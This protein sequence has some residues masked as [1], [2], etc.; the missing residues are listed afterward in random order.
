MRD[1][2]LFSSHIHVYLFNSSTTTEVLTAV[3]NATLIQQQTVGD[4]ADDNA[5][6]NVVTQQLEEAVEAVELDEEEERNEL[7]IEA[8]A[9]QVLNFSQPS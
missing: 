2:A 6:K 1:F 7:D 8:P 4:G 5:N 3:A 9:E